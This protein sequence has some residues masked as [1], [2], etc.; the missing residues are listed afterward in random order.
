MDCVEAI[1]C[2][3][4]G[5]GLTEEG[6][7]L[8][9]P[10]RHTFDISRS[11][12][13]NLLPSTRKLPETVGDSAEMLAARAQFLDAG[14]FD[15]LIDHLRGPAHH[16]G[17][18]Y[19]VDVGSGTGHYLAALGDGSACRFGIDISKTAARMGATR[20]KDIT[21]LVADV[22]RGIPLAS[23][24]AGLLL[25]IFSPR[26]PAEFA[27]VLHPEGTAVVVI[28]APDHLAELIERFDLLQVQDD[29]E[30]IVL[31]AFEGH[32]SPRDREHITFEMTLT[33]DAL[34][35]LVGMGPSARHPSEDRT[36]ALDE[37]SAV[38]CTASFV[39]LSFGR[40]RS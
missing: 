16:P 9:C 34:R 7:S 26:N 37:A 4:C 36:R 32:L 35:D 10:A 29:K 3:L 14:Y 28:P 25:D 13:V 12:Y 40:A 6:N 2:P 22:H 1:I 17:S 8:V 11:G 38:T 27:R 15:S 23:E 20:H 24:G 39:V 19:V 31:R 30:D 18:G 33:G 5:E 21:F